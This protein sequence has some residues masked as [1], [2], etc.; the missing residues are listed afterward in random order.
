MPTVHDW[1][2]NPLGVV[3]GMFGKKQQSKCV[4]PTNSHFEEEH[5]IIIMRYDF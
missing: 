4:F 2:N 5:V 1:I 3:D